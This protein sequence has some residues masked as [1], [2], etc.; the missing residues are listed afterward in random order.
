MSVSQEQA[1]F[2]LVCETVLDS[3]SSTNIF[4][5]S[6]PRYGELLASFVLRVLRPVATDLRSSY[7]CSRCHDLFQMLEQAQWTVSSVKTEILKVYHSRVTDR[8]DER[9][10]VVPEAHVSPN[11]DM[12]VERSIDEKIIVENGQFEDIHELRSLNVARNEFDGL[13]IVIDNL[14]AANCVI[15]AKR[16]IEASINDHAQQHNSY[17]IDEP[18]LESGTKKP[19]ADDLAMMKNCCS[20]EAVLVGN[21]SSEFTKNSPHDE[22][23][24]VG[25]MISR[26]TNEFEFQSSTAHA[27]SGIQDGGQDGD[28]SEVMSSSMER[29]FEAV[30]DAKSLYTVQCG[31]C[32][33]FFRSTTDLQSHTLRHGGSRPYKCRECD[34]RFADF[35]GASEHS[36]VAH[37][38]AK[39]CVQLSSEPADNEIV[40]FSTEDWILPDDF[41]K[42]GGDEAKFRAGSDDNDND[43]RNER[44]SW[45]SGRISKYSQKPL[46]YSCTTCGKKWRT[47][48]ELKTHV[49]SHSNLRP[50]M[51]EKCGQAYKHKHALEIHVGMHNGVSPFQCSVCNKCFTQ[52]GALMRHLPMH[53]G[54]TPYQCELCGKR[55]VHH[56]SYNMHALSHTGKKSYQCHVSYRLMITV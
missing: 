31:L 6:L 48:A 4:Y 12:F 53:T 24:N 21:V 26:I 7:I 46:K 33:R 29:N 16:D 45:K 34:E 9:K 5:S 25:D 55:F 22:R 19:E 18:K 43:R 28:A 38:A 44:A 2:C 20:S 36:T 11:D 41:R 39:N 30:N 10:T 17:K 52:K 56:T 23:E 13:S 27:Q 15:D 35:S 42:N 3:S 37:S 32:G 14:N 8:A 51:C 50:Y 40:D 49:K 1:S 47:S 54:E